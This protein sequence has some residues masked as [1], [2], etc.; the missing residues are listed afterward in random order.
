MYKQ[1]HRTTSQLESFNASLSVITPAKF[2][3]FKIL[4]R[5]ETY[6][7]ETSQ[8]LE[9]V[10]QKC[11][12]PSKKRSKK[13]QY[14]FENIE[15]CTEQFENQKM[16]VAKFLEYIVLDNRKRLSALE[17][18]NYTYAED[19]VSDEE[20]TVSEEAAIEK[21]Y[22]YVCNMKISNVLFLPCRQVVVCKNCYSA[23]IEINNQTAN[24]ASN[25]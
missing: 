17:A 13:K 10:V 7:K 11:G 23:K 6:I 18:S 25:K 1:E 16:D 12:P 3:F 4:S 2:N 24:L 19:E 22:C 5:L 9:K 14:N 21:L 8:R 20:D 15:F